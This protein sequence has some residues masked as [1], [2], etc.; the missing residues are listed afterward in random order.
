[1]DYKDF[2]IDKTILIQFY[3]HICSPHQHKVK[4]LLLRVKGNANII[5]INPNIMK[6]FQISGVYYDLIYRISIF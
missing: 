4:Y 2:N 1:M 6:F 5:P 3:E